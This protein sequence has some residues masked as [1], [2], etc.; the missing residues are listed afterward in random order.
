MGPI[1]RSEFLL[2]GNLL[3]GLAVALVPGWICSVP[4]LLPVSLAHWLSLHCSQGP[5]DIRGKSLTSIFLASYLFVLFS[6][7]AVCVCVCVICMSV[8]VPCAS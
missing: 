8:C 5:H 1:S 2:S 7:E 4:T 3:V 6:F